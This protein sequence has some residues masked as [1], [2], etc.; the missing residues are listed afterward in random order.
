MNDDLIIIPARAYHRFYLTET[1][2][3]RCTR[4]FLNHE[5]WAPLYRD[6]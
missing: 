2:N 4:L 3:I 6:A 5:G 1:K